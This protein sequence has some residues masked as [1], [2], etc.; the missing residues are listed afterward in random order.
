MSGDGRSAARPAALA[1]IARELPAGAVVD[2]PDLLLG[3]QIDA[4][5]RYGG[6]A[7]ALIRPRTVAEVQFAVGACS[8][9]GL[10]LVAQGGNTGLVGGGVPRDG[11]VVLSLGRLDAIAEVD[12]AANQVVVGAG[13]TLGAVQELAARSGLEFPLDHPARIAATIGGSIATNAGGAL[14]LRHGTM[15]QRVAGLEAV[16]PAGGVVSR[17]SGLFKDNAGL[18]L[19]SLIVGSEGTLGVITAARL[20]LE[21]ARPQR[22]TALLGAPDFEAAQQILAALRPLEGLEAVD[23]LDDRCMDLVRGR[24]R[25]RDPLDEEAGCYLVAQVAGTDDP[26]PALVEALSVLSWEPATAVAI[27][28]AGRARLWAYREL[29]NESLREVGIPHK[30]D[31][32]VPLAALPEFCEA[33]RREVA[34]RLPDASTYL[35]GHIGDGNVHVNVLGPDPDDDTADELVLRLA[36]ERGGTISAEHGIGIAKTRYLDLCRSPEDIAAMIAIKAALDPANVLG[37]GRILEAPPTA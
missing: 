31:V 11:E 27:D 20:Q 14:A 29:I 17:M 33:V 22:I 10:P 1:S 19:P 21:P 6:R 12:H 32:A 25:L 18:D 35:Y 23:F 15:K 2:D 9:A 7:L 8:A 13:A 24:R 4:T 28:T 26:A 36:C 5:G 16:L 34:D 30:L 37:R 3:C